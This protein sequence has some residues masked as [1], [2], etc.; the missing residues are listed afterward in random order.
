MSEKAARKSSGPARP[1]QR[2]VHRREHP[3]VRVDDERVGALDARERPA[4]LLA[5][6]RRARV[7][8]V[9]VQPGAGLRAQR[10]RPPRTGS[11]E[12]VE[13]VPTVGT[14]TATSSRSSAS[15]RI[16]NSSS[17]G[18]LRSS[19]PSI[20]A[21]FSTDECACSEQTTTLRPVTWRAAI[22]AASVEVEA[23]SSMWPCQPVG[24]AEQLRDPV[25]DEP[26]ELGRRRRGAPQ[27]R[28][29]VERGGEQLGEDP[30]LARR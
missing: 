6:H 24:Q 25:A 14:T 18:T 5:D 21:P 27:E 23:V 4:L 26:L 13:V 28:H 30:R 11:T 16:R 10:R 20:R 9:D 1:E 29:L 8:G 12:A 15:G 3:L 22:S 17:A 7:G 19:I 2:A